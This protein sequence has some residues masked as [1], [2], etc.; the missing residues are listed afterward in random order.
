MARVWL[1]GNFGLQ[2]LKGEKVVH[3][4]F[5]LTE[6]Y[7]LLQM[8]PPHDGFRRDIENAIRAIESR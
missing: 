7:D 4:E 2:H 8:I 1:C 6:L 3:V 5:N